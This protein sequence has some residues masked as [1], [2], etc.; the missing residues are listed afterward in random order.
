[1]D[2]ALFAK[3]LA[4]VVLGLAVAVIIADTVRSGTWF[5]AAR[6]PPPPLVDVL[7]E[8]ES[9]DIFDPPYVVMAF[10]NND[11]DWATTGDTIP[12][13]ALRWRHCPTPPVFRRP[14]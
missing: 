6:N 5:D 9:G 13:R 2:P 12:V 11:G 7:V 14:G 8:V 3:L 4:L 10:M 1:M